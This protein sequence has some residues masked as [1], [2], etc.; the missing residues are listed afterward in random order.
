MRRVR[1]VPLARRNLRS[2]IRKLTETE[3]QAWPKFLARAWMI[4]AE[5][6]DRP[7]VAKQIAIDAVT[8]AH[9]C[10]VAMSERAQANARD[11]ARCEVLSAA[12]A[13]FNC[14]RRISAPVRRTL[15]EVAQSNFLDGNADSE[16]VARFFDEC[17]RVVTKFPNIKDAERIRIALSGL[18][19]KT[20]ELSG[21]ILDGRTLKMANDYEALHP[22]DRVVIEERLRR[23]ANNAQ[24]SLAARDVYECLANT[25]SSA[26]STDTQEK[27]GDLLIAYVAEIAKIWRQSGLHPG[28]ARQ[29]NNPD[30]RN[31][32]HLFLELVLIDQVDPRSRLF[33]RPSD[34]E[35]KVAGKNHAAL[36]VDERRDAGIGP[37][38]TWLI[39]EHHLKAAVGPDSKKRP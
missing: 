11:T 37:R 31:P 12:L 22:L 19:D 18:D 29:E 36:P 2:F 25:L 23:L 21:D 8:A 24:A 27:S 15:N 10:A 5:R 4:V 17:F 3:P 13:I 6:L 20:Y 28:R 38:L 32:F 14:V 7:D 1:A 33:D 26:T 34:D 16:A 9:G 30:Y 39:S 35:L